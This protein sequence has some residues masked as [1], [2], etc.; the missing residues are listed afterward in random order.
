MPKTCMAQEDR[1][2]ASAAVAACAPLK[3]STMAWTTFW[4]CKV[5]LPK[6]CKK[7]VSAANTQ[8]KAVNPHGWNI[9][10][11]PCAH[12]GIFFLPKFVWVINTGSIACLWGATVS[13]GCAWI[14]KLRCEA[15][16][17]WTKTMKLIIDCHCECA[18][19][20]NNKKIFVG[21]SLSVFLHT[22][23]RTEY[24]YQ[25]IKCLVYH[26]TDQF[27]ILRTICHVVFVLVLPQ[28][29]C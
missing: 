11:F 21:S 1:K 4:W 12:G 2:A 20:Q 14:Y 16:V 24:T 3:F 7:A 28:F 26:V 23:L 15:W 25:W 5:L 18:E 9:Q 6:S 13:E 29:W 22:T 10:W 8:P 17:I 19:T 27:L